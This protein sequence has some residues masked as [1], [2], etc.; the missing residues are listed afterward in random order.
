M[1]TKI[2]NCSNRDDLIKL[3]KILTLDLDKIYKRTIFQAMILKQLFKLSGLKF[4]DNLDHEELET[5]F[6]KY[7]VKELK[8][9]V[10]QESDNDALFNNIIRKVRQFK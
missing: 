3:G 2:F 5:T 10:P 7:W 8:V 1:L 6:L 9:S 4:D